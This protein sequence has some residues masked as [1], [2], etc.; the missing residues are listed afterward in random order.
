MLE[1]LRTPDSSEGQTAGA[2]GHGRPAFRASAAH[3]MLSQPSATFAM[4]FLG[5]MIAFR[6]LNVGEQGRVVVV[7]AQQSRRR[8]LVRVEV[9]VGNSAGHARLQRKVFSS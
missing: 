4:A 8:V 3:Q 7:V 6:F 1:S 2:R 9:E 5:L